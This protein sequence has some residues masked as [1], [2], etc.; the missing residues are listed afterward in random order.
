M[1]AA[2]RKTPTQSGGGSDDGVLYTDA[3]NVEV[4]ALWRYAGYPLTGVAGSNAITAAS[5][6]AVVAAITA[7][8]TGMK[9]S[10]IPAATNTGGVTINIDTVGVVNLK[11]AGGATLAAGDLVAGRMV[12][13]EYDGTQWRV[14]AG[15]SASAAQAFSVAP[16]LMLRDEKAQNTAGGTATAGSWYTRTI[17]TVV[18]NVLAGASL[19]ANEFTLQ[20]GTYRVTASAPAAQCNSHQVRLYNV[21]DAAIVAK[22][23]GSS[24][25]ID[26]AATAQTR[27]H[28]DVVLT[29]TAAKVFRL[30]QQVET[31]R[32]TDG[33][34]LPANFTTEVY[35][36]V[37]VWKVGTLAS[38]VDGVAGG[39]VTWPVTFSTTTTDADPGA[40]TLRLN[41]ATQTAATAIY[42]DLL[43]A[44][45][46]DVTAVI[47]SLDDSTN[48][49]KGELRLVKYDDPTKW[50]TFNV[51]AWTTAAGY[52]KLTVANLA[53]SAASPFA[54]ADRLYLTFTRAGDKGDTGAQGA[55]AGDIPWLFDSSIT[56]ADP[57]T[58]DVRLNNATLAS[59]TAIAISASS[60]ASG[61]PAVGNWVKAWDDL[62]TSAARGYLVVRKTAAPQ[63][64]AIYKISGTVTD[65]AT[66]M[67]FTVAHISS[68]GSFANT[69][70]LSIQFTPAATDSGAR[71]LIETKTA[72]ASPTIDFTMGLDDTYDAYEIVISNLKPATDDVE[73]WLRIGTGGGPTYQTAGYRYAT[74]ATH[75]GGGAN[76][77]S[78]SDAKIIL[79]GIGAGSSVGNAAGEHY[80]ATVHFQNP[81]VTTDF[82]AFYAIGSYVTA[83]GQYAVFHGG[84]MFATVGAITGIR[85]MF[86]SGNI[87]SGGI[88][89]YGVKKS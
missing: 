25:Q 59:V 2:L 18:R 23:E 61:N 73:V 68:A 31:T 44:N 51:T 69:D 11:D 36:V 32:A 82:V 20:A 9:R 83:G 10:L 27:S 87:A 72:S 70:G 47:D 79:T 35:A 54:A 39:A 84:G 60:A 21:T 12:G 33:Q 30:E 67:Q 5:D 56:M 48:A 13:I 40:G 55:D 16:D 78:T 22:G 7:Y 46:T 76:A 85:L 4:A 15:G 86:E 88:S 77:A 24:E 34:G 81:E 53:G 29:I 43:D 14:V 6:T 41:N 26:S 71:L 28:L 80:N 37:S 63:N 45:L 50:L 57:G 74:Q 49:V 8:A 89:L 65:N 62:G 1:P 52:R 66:W 75:D 17:N 19:S 64:Y 58:G 38:E 42:V 3:V